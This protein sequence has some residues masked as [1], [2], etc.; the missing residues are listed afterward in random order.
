M[1][2]QDPPPVNQQLEGTHYPTDEQKSPKNQQILESMRYAKRIQQALCTCERRLRCVFP[3]SFM[4]HLP[5]C[6][7]SGDFVYLQQKR[8]R[9]YL[10]VGDC[11]GHGIPA[12]LLTVIS[13]VQLNQLI[14]EAGKEIE[15]AHILYTFD[16]LFT[17]QLKNEESPIIRD[18][19]EMA[20]CIIDQ[21]ERVLHFG[22]ARQ[23]LYYICHNELH[24][25]KG[26][27]DTLGWS[28]KTYLQ[29]DFQTI[30]IPLQPDQT[31]RFYF[32]TDGFANQFNPEGKK[33]TPKNFRAM[34]KSISYLPM[35]EQGDLL[36]E[37]FLQW[38]GDSKQ[39]DDVLI[40]GFQV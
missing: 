25:Y 9:I 28:L 16:F 13:V 30:S 39:I 33:L 8:E 19:V 40:I 1:H 22:G 14:E 20:V 4:F 24:H 15:P 38:K 17:E 35:Q 10:V 12:S 34:L 6:E 36:K 23:S 29:K 7:L 3:N 27:R 31:N 18:G 32:A 5:K 37:L 21:R 26:S 2:M 11:T